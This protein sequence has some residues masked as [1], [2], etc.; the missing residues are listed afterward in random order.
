[1]AQAKV[2]RQIERDA[3]LLSSPVSSKTDL[4]QAKA[5]KDRWT[6]F[7]IELMN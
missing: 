1:M 2:R 7:N 4:D 6:D 5:A 3:Q